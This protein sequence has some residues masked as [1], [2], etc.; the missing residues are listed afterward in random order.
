M[1]PSNERHPGSERRLRRVCAPLRYVS[2]GVQTRARR[3]KL[4]EFQDQAWVSICCAGISCVGRAKLAHSYGSFGPREVNKVPMG[5]RDPAHFFDAGDVAYSHG[6]FAS[7][8]SWAGNADPS[9]DK[10]WVGRPT[11]GISGLCRSYITDPSFMVNIV[12]ISVVGN[13]GSD[14]KT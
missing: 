5:M 10:A 6:S 14:S 11:R 13:I 2:L 9:A 8:S 4:C 1:R 3:S 7:A 12:N